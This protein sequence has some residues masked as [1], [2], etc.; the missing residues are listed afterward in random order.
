MHS[1]FDRSPHTPHL[2]LLTTQALT[3]VVLKCTSM[4]EV[5]YSNSS[6]IWELS[7]QGTQPGRAYGQ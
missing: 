2:L 3:A 1:M 5:I 4:A 7:L 6:L